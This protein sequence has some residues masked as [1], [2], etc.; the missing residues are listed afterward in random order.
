MFR[1]R[2]FLL[3]SAMAS[4]ITPSISIAVSVALPSIA[5]SFNVDMAF[6]N[7]FA[8]V[9]LVSMASTILLLGVVA[10]WLGKELMFVIGVAIFMATAFLVLCGGDFTLLLLLRCVQGL[11]AAMISGTAVAILA[12]LFPKET[13]SLLE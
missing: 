1:K 11:G 9:F 13:A 2:L 7:W 6:V 12:S 10:D 5:R 8:N 4:F 3:S